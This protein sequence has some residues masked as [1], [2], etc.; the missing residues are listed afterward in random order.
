MKITAWVFCFALLADVLAV[1]FGWH[2][3]HN[4][5]KPMLMPLLVMYALIQQSNHSKAI[6]LL[7]IAGLMFAWAGDIFLMFEHKNPVFFLA[8]LSSFLCTH[9]CYILMFLKI[10]AQK[11]ERKKIPRG[12]WLGIGLYGLALVILLWPGLGDMKIPVIIYAICIC[13]M[14]MLSV[15]TPGNMLTKTKFVLVAGAFLFVISDSVLAIN[16][17]VMAGPWAPPVIMLTYG[18]AQFAIVAGVSNLLKSTSG[19]A[20]IPAV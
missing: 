2:E 18:L 3:I 7:L 5:I 19:E 10:N 20:L 15:I 16:K 11:T 17:F 12:V 6:L 13:T 9:I 4:W 8:G 1:G 14:A